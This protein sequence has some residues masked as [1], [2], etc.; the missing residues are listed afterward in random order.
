MVDM[1]ICQREHRA[2][3]A[4]AR[5]DGKVSGDSFIVYLINH[6]RHCWRPRRAQRSVGSRPHLCGLMG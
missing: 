2:A 6:I 3:S 4:V 5:S 1:L